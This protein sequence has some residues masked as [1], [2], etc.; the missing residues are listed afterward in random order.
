M[1]QKALPSPMI[2][3]YSIV[4]IL[5]VISFICYFY[6]KWGPKTHYPTL[7]ELQ[8]S[9]GELL[10]YSITE[11]SKNNKII[12]RL[13]NENVSFVFNKIDFFPQ[14]KAELGKGSIVELWADKEEYNK[15]KPSEV[16]QLNLN[17][18]QI[19]SLSTITNLIKERRSD[20]KYFK[21]VLFYIGI[22][23]F[24]AFKM[25]DHFASRKSKE[26]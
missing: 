21:Y 24:I 10:D 4:Y 6:E 15:G 3:K 18:K 25:Q 19:M 5:I 1:N 20:L 8:H 23:F 14:A 26:T 17:G 7:S 22:A 12:L 13:K 2:S 16:W 11:S 9:S